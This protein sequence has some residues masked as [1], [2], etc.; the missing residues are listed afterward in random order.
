MYL[1][2]C[3]SEVKMRYFILKYNFC[4]K[5]VFDEDLQINKHVIVCKTFREIQAGNNVF[6]LKLGILKGTDCW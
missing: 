4:S 1:S 3:I 6:L 5:Y 2:M